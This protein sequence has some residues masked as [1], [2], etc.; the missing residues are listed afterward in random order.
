MWVQYWVGESILTSWRSSSLV[1]TSFPVTESNTNVDAV[2][3][4]YKCQH[5]SVDLKIGITI[6]F[7]HM[8]LWKQ[9]FST[10]GR[11]GSWRDVPLLAQ[12]KAMCVLWTACLGRVC[13]EWN[14]WQP[15]IPVK[16]LQATTSRETGTSVWQLQGSACC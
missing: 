1:C 13:V 12:K 5:R 4:F 9:S 16:S 2:K 15:V 8:N 14:G 3:G 11:K 7:H 6:W 10:G